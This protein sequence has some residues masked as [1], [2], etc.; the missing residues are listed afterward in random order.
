M[1]YYIHKIRVNYA[2]I[3][4]D[5]IEI[6]DLKY[7]FFKNSAIFFCSN[8]MN[9]RA[10][11]IKLIYIE[12][13]LSFLQSRLIKSNLI[14]EI[15]NWDT[16]VK[17]SSWHVEWTLVLFDILTWYNLIEVILNFV[18]SLNK[19]RMTDSFSMLMSL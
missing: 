14:N 9:Y 8:V 18:D 4:Q 3:V 16:N 2:R 15:N 7:C 1:L 19:S 12:W 10:S 17:F 11:L 13:F 5:V 6:N